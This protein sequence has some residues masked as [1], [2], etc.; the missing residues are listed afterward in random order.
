[1]RV[2]SRAPRAN[3]WPS[4]SAVCRCWGLGWI[5]VAVLSSPGHGQEVGTLLPS[6]RSS[7]ERGLQGEPWDVDAPV[8]VQSDRLTVE[9]EA[10]RIVF[11]GNVRVTQSDFVL[12]AQ[13]VT[14]VFGKKAEDIVRITA[15]GGVEIRKADKVAWGELA[16]Y[17]RKR[18]R[19]QLS[20]KPYLRQGNNYLRGHEIDVLL[21]EDRMEIRG[22]VEAEFHLPPAQEPGADG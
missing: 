9:F 6:A 14:A 4:R 18:A 1:M 17:D 15:K 13:E 2:G 16:V 19:I 8:D 5:L 20:G 12:T 11:Q 3:A 7:L 21:E 22:G 10:H